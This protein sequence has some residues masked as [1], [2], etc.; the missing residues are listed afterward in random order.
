MFSS[1][2]RQQWLSTARLVHSIFTLAMFLFMVRPLAAQGAPEGLWNAVVVVGP[3]EIPFQFEI[4]HEGDQW[5]GFFFEGNKKIGSTSGSYAAGTLRLNYEFLNSTLTAA[6][7]GDHWDGTYRYNRKNGKEYPLHAHRYVTAGPA[8]SDPPQVAG[9]WEMKLVGDNGVVTKDPRHA[10]S[11]KL[12]LRQSGG[13]VTG[14]IL[15]VD[16]DTGTLTGHW[17]HDS[18][19]LS[20]FVGERPVLF[21]AKLQPDGTLDILLNNQ[22]RYLAAR[23]SDAR[24]KGIPEPPNPF[25]YTSVK[26]PSEPFHFRFPDINGRIV[27]DADGQFKNKVVILAIGG[28]WCPNCRD[29]AP[30]L[31]ELY[32]KFHDQGLEIVGLNFEASG[33]LADDKPRVESFIEE[34]SVPYPI[35]Y[36]GTIGEVTEKL[37]QIEN[38]GAYPTTI[39]LGRDGLVA[40]IHAGFAS[41]ATGE[42][43]NDLERDVTGLLQRLLNEKVNGPTAQAQQAPV[44]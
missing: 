26:N 3:A 32:Q 8:P 30:L 40:S 14:S 28:T 29:E 24:S 4:R 18:L 43:H 11:W 16:G 31:V 33:N 41:S 34:F 13:D 9:E 19:V 44:P 12:F 17:Q 39:Y 23:T 7:E 10:P 35:L 1:G 20:H 15:R 38:F 25:Q 6:F 36:V 27:S 21:E 22:S 37:P 5:E 2:Q 42:A